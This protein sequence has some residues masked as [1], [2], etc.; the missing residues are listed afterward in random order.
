MT[1]KIWRLIFSPVIGASSWRPLSPVKIRASISEIREILTARTEVTIVQCKRYAPHKFRELLRAAKLE[2][3]KLDV[4]KPDRYVLFTSVPLSP[5]NK[6]EL[7]RAL[8]PWCKTTGDIYGATEVNGLLRKHPQ[9]EQ[10]HF[11]L[12]IASTAVLE[13]LLHSRIFN[14]TQATLESTKAFL[15]RIVIHDAF[16]R[17]LTMLYQDHHVLIVGNPGIG[18]TTLARILLCHY[19]REGFEPLCVTGNIDDAWDLVY[20]S[21]GSSRKIV[22]LYDD[23]LGR[24]RF[25][26]QRFGKNEELSLLE[27]LSKVRRS[28]N[29]RL[30]FTT[31]EYILADAQRIHGAFASH[32]NK[33]LKCTLTLE[34][35]SRIHR[36][37]M[38][39]NHLYFSDLPDSRL[40]LL[41]K[42]GVYNTIVEHTH[43][44]PRIVETISTHANS[45]ALSDREYIQFIER[46][47]D[48]PSRIWEHPFR[49][50]ISPLART[51]LTVLWTFGGTAELEILKSAVARIDGSQKTSEFTL[52]FEDALRQLD[53]NF[54]STN[55]YPGGWGKDKSFTVAQFH[56]PSVE[57]F[58]DNRVQSDPGSVEQLK[59]GIVCFR[60]VSELVSHLSGCAKHHAL[61]VSF[62]TA[63]R[64]AAASTENSPGGYLINVRSYGEEIRRVWDTG[65]PDWPRQTL[66]RLQIER[67]VKIEDS[68]LAELQARVLTSTG[69]LQL[70]RNIPHDESDA[71]A[72]SSLHEWL[73]KD[74]GW[75]EKTKMACHSA[76]REAV[77]QFIEDEDQVWPCSVCALR[78][79]AE[80]VS[81]RKTSF[82]DREKSSFLA[83]SRLVV[84]TIIDNSDDA[85]DVSTEADE[86]TT[87]KDI[88]GIDVGVQIER[89]ESRAQSLL[90]RSDHAESGDP[91]SKYISK[92]PTTEPF[93]VDSLFMG[94]LDR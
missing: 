51:V 50:D 62:W 89:L 26:S 25:D 59:R 84:Q 7:L 33:I 49:Y 32:A 11:K 22:V 56:N 12:W 87:L 76:F 91:E 41:L 88:C 77:L 44:N 63:I 93:D 23:F 53:G 90:E 9:V 68:L 78:M 28:P 5:D 10:A 21:E 55:R 13:R 47:F 61:G 82:T 16:N 39:F 15:S 80:V 52:Q 94:L 29:L 48:N 79:L 73:V 40:S 17:A 42:K 36:A 60:Q 20:E 83:A 35:Y 81:F 67:E 8:R 74:S 65:K 45:R 69:W 30:I 72:V 66:V 6:G 92:E 86:L 70:I 38:L 37:K 2:K 18:K 75:P 71:Y 85:H 14:V 64:K 3:R 54:I 19:L 1:W 27:F 43:F 58:I 57:E 34:D 31:R 4:L 24:L 46:E